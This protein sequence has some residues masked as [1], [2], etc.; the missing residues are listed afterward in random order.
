M[1]RSVRRAM[2][3]A[4]SLLVAT[5]YLYLVLNETSLASSE[6]SVAPPI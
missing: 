5:A 1:K 3:T 2:V 6:A 4:R